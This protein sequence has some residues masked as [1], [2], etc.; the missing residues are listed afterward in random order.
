MKDELEVLHD[1]YARAL[2]MCARETRSV[3]RVMEELSGLNEEWLKDEKFSYFLVHPLIGRDEKKS[4]I[5]RLLSGKKCCDTIRNF[6]DMLIDNRRENLIH[7][8]FLRYRDLYDEFKEKIRISVET[9]E[10]P[11]ESERKILV[12]TLKSKFHED[13]DIEITEKPEL[14]GGILIKYRDRIYDYSLKGQLRM[15]SRKLAA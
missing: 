9:A 15:M 4:V 6:L 13:V 5:H 2:F 11:S 7:G 8:V 10:P 3:D 14:I 12:K 1:R